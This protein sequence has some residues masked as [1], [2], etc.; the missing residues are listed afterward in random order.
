MHTLLVEIE[1][2]TKAKELN[3]M[4]SSM[5]FVKKVSSI[6]KKAKLIKALE[7]HEM[8]KTSILKNKNKAIAKYL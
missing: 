6:N 7:E 2:A 4:L 5:N 8:L 1:S 3:S